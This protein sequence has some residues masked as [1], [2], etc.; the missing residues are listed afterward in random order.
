M[1]GNVVVEEQNDF[2][3][4]LQ[5]QT[6]FA[7]YLAEARTGSGDG[8]TPVL[9]EA[10]PDFRGTSLSAMRLEPMETDGTNLK[11]KF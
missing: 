2:D 10:T 3:A 6:T 9:G 7:E 5:E 4:W 11:G 8:S 1:R